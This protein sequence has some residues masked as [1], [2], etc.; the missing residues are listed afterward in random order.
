LVISNS[1]LA[2]AAMFL[3]VTS[4]SDAGLLKRYGV[5]ENNSALVR[6]RQISELAG[7]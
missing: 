3:L 5:L 7:R 4:I 6:G 1:A 2:A